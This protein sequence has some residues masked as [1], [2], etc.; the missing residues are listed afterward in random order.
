MKDQEVIKKLQLLKTLQP[1]KHTLK[2]I[3]ED[4]YYQVQS[5]NKKQAYFSSQDILSNA[6]SFI[7]SYDINIYASAAAFLLIIFLSIYVILFPNQIHNSLLYGELTL[8]PNQYTKSRIAL[9][10]TKSRFTDNKIVKKNTNELAYSL[11]LTNNQ[12]NAL[13][14]K[15]EE[16]KYTA[17][18]CHKIYQEYISY[19]ENT[20]KVI[21]SNNLNLKSQINS[22]E[23]QAERKI[24]MYNSL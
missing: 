8:A 24:H 17:E 9:E 16:G 10:D 11:T 23:E 22:Y 21:P 18:E 20:E 12:L 5:K 7:K 6:S 19:L 15:G 2:K 3:K 4:V 1:T 14:L 13:K